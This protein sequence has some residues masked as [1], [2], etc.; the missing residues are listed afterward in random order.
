MLKGFFYME[1]IKETFDS[2]GGYDPP[3]QA[4]IY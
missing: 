2:S 1:F 4:G 3:V